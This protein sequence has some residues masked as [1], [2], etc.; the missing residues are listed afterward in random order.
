MLDPTCQLVPWSVRH[1]FF[2]YARAMALRLGGLADL[3]PT[4]VQLPV[5]TEV[6]TRVD[7]ALDGP[8][9]E[10]RTQGA[11]GRVAALEGD[12]VDVVF[13]DGKRGTYLRHALTPRKLGE[14]RYAHRRAAAWDE[15]RPCV[16]IDALVGSRAWGVAGEGSDE[17]HRGVFVLPAPWTV[18]LVDPPLD[19]VSAG[20]SHTYWEPARRSARRCAPIRTRSRCCSPC[21]GSSI[22]S[23]KR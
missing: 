17:D 4:T 19:L 5:G 14:L 23:A 21:R 16:V 8:D 12:R 1:D 3:D 9:G 13:V 6:T 10:V 11:T 22:R 15:L 2:T 20:G 18:G 7:R